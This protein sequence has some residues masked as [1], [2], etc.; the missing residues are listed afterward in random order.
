MKKTPTHLVVDGSNIATE[1][2]QMPSLSQ[3]EEAVDA[4]VTEQFGSVR[5]LR[6]RHQ[7][8]VAG[9]ASGTAAGDRARLTRADLG[10]DT[11]RL[12]PGT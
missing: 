9:W 12:G 7:L 11:R 2:R 1:G 4:F 3:L 10:H 5:P 6:M 8:D